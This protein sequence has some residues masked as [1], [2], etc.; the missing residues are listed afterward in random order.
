MAREGGSGD[1]LAGFILGGLIGG[2]LALLFAPTTGEEMRGQIR[3]KGI[4]LRNLAEDL[5]LEKIK[6]KGRVLVG[7]QRARFQEA[8]EEGKLAAARKKEQLL[9]QLESSGSS[10]RPIDLTGLKA[11]S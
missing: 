10:D 8:V 9:A 7:E 4:E 6:A 5:D 11:S 3:E 2:A 1:F